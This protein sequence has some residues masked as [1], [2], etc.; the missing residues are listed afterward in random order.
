MLFVRL[1][2]FGK[3]QAEKY[4]HDLRH[5]LNAIADNPQIAAE[6]NNFNPPVR[7]HHHAK[8]YIIYMNEEDHILVIR[9]LRDEVD[10]NKHL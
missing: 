9:I 2:K 3:A 8:H 1:R 4:E 6:R 10:L 7:I 5:I